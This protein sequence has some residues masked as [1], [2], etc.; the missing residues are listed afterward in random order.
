MVKK[1]VIEIFCNGCKWLMNKD[2]C[3]MHKYRV[4][5]YRSRCPY[6]DDSEREFDHEYFYK[7]CQ[8]FCEMY[9]D[10]KNN[11]NY[12]K[13]EDETFN[14]GETELLSYALNDIQREIQFYSNIGLYENLN[15]NK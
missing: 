11:H 7:L 6:F 8:K 9:K 12:M 3:D 1:N 10:F 5:P 2:W 4:E 15:N 13:E 14:H